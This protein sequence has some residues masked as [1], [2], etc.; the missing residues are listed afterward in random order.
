M[1]RAA[2]GL[3]GFEVW[4]ATVEGRLASTLFLTR[5]GDC[6]T[7]LSQ[8]S[9]AELWPLHANHALAY[10]VSRAA[11]AR[12]GVTM[13][14]YGLQGLD[15]PPSVDDFKCHLG[16]RRRPVR[17]HVDF[18]PVVAP[19]VTPATHALLA[20]ARDRFRGSAVLAKGEGLARIYVEAA[21]VPTPVATVAPGPGAPAGPDRGP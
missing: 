14:H 10:E 21:R 1:A 12:P 9:L 3:P 18:H 13:L 5:V 16:F 15:A 4:G 8:Q 6:V 20:R 11:R 7:Y 2:D 17:Y 19:F